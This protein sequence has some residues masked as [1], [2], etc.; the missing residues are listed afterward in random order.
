M[1]PDVRADARNRLPK[2]AS[3]ELQRGLLRVVQ[4]SSG[5]DGDGAT[6]FASTRQQAR[7]DHD[8]CATVENRP[9]RAC[10]WAWT[11][12]AI[13]A[14]QRCGTVRSGE[15][16]GSAGPMADGGEEPRL[17]RPHRCCGGQ[18]LVLSGDPQSRR[19]ARRRSFCSATTSVACAPTTPPRAPWA[20]LAV[21]RFS[22]DSG[23]ARRPRSRAWCAGRPAALAAA[24]IRTRRTRRVPA[25]RTRRR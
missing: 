23:R 24:A 6:A 3:R 9:R 20:P 1:C 4:P 12:P 5:S 22:G 15:A 11:T 8:G 25:C 7:L 13:H 21:L 19:S 10:V 2:Q 17:G 14:Q 16:R 18:A